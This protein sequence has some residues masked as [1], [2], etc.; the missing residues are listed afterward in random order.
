MDP[1]AISVRQAV[2]ADVPAMQRIRHAVRENRLTSR[3]L[4]DADVIEAIERRGRGWVAEHGG[5][6]IG[7]AVGNPETGNVWALFVDPAFEG[8]GAGRRLH[9]EMVGWLRSRGLT[10]LWL[11]TEPGTRAERFYARL[12]WRRIGLQPD[13]EVRFELEL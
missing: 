6:I 13:G 3:I 9:D 12:G 11:G 5:E 1:S 8:R 2:R 10:R 7:F 4:R